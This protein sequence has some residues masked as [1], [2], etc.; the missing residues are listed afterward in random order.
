MI[1]DENEF[2]ERISKPLRSSESFGQAFDDRVMAAVL[3]EPARPGAWGWLVRPRTI[4]L[5]PIGGFALA[6]AA[7]AL[8][9]LALGFP[10]DNDASR[11]ASTPESPTVTTSAPAPGIGRDTVRIVQFVFVA[12]GARTVSLVG[13]FNDWN[14]A[15]TPLES[16]HT[17]GVWTV[18]VPLNAGRHAYGFMIDGQ[19]LVSD[20]GAPA[21]V[22]DG[23]GSRSS[24]VTVTEASS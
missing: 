11:I 15:A 14:E 22:D 4:R 18:S 9:A 1:Q 7:V 5:S 12:P 20:P 16:S 17:R 13:D 6:A 3:A 24:V 23:F 10:R 8:F 19:R 21:T 2:I